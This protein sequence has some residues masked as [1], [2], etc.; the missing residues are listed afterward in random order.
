MI[1]L[2]TSRVYSI[3]PLRSIELNEIESRFVVSPN[4]KVPGSSLK[5][6]SENFPTHLP[7]SL[8]GATKLASE[9]I[10]QEYA[11]TYKFPCIINR[12]GVIAGP[13]QFGKVDQGV[14]TMWVANHIYNKPLSYIG[15]GGT[16]K[17]VRDL[18]HP[19][20]LYDLLELQ[21]HQ[22]NK[23]SGQSFNAGGGNFASTSLLE[24]TSLCEIVSERSVSISSKPETHAVDIPYYVSDNSKVSQTFGWQPKRDVKVIVSDIASWI[25]ENYEFLR[26]IFG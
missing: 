25:K 2:S 1:F 3:G 5:G 6:I 16:G 21:L 15:F 23:Y 12:C 13:G 8:Y 26:P 24:L 7:R 20:D 19:D 4:S 11:D 22:L 14:F 10:L 17:Q 9:M 18:L